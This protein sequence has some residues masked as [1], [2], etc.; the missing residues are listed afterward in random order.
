MRP[1]DFATARTVDE[2]LAAPVDGSAYLAGGTTLVDLMKLEVMTPRHVVDIN[3]LALPGIRLDQRG[4]HLGALERMSDVAAH[5][6]VTAGYPVLAQALL[7]SAS[8]QLRN[9]ASIGGNLLQR[10][11]CGYFRDTA[12]PC[13]KREPG[14]GCPALNGENRMHA[15]LGTS[16]SCVSTHPSD[17]AVALVALDASVELRGR[18]GTR[19]VRLAEFYLRP[20]DSPEREFDLHPGELVTG[21]LVP[22]LDWARRSAYLK[23]RDRAS[24]EF[25]LSSAAVAVDLDGPIVRDVRVAVGGVATTPWRLP[26]VEDALRNRPLRQDL[27]ESAAQRAVEGAH[28]LAHNGFKV[29]LL[30]RTIVRALMSLKD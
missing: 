30:Q 7:A 3:H 23:I 29:A 13:N 12:T 14:T 5:P 21:V 22:R 19:S 25:A 15:I 16:G 1:Y 18:T 28:P 17:L 4:L 27:A 6:L 9:M 10:S 11:R 2:A 8:P 20:G 24:Y 26:A